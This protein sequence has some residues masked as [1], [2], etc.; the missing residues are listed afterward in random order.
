MTYTVEEIIATLD[1]KPLT[2]EGGYY[3]E[4]Y[5]ASEWIPTTGLPVRYKSA[6]AFST[7]IYY[8]LTPSTFSA[9]HKLPTDEIFHF[10]LGDTVE[11]LQLFED[12]TGKVVKIGNDIRAGA[13][14]QVVV[15]RNTWQGTQLMAGGAFALLGTTMSPSFEF[16]DFIP[17][18]R[19]ALLKQY[20]AFAERIKS[21]T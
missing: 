10:Y 9:L 2:M 4:T 3:K 5:R 18:N 17:P 19:E 15:P 8:L 6:R 1:L 16:E 13:Y 20:P 12:G 11:M 14:P 21:L 7:A